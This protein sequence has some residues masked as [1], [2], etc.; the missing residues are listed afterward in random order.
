MKTLPRQ[1]LTQRQKVARAFGLS[2]RQL[3]RWIRF[4]ES[5]SLDWIRCNPDRATTPKH[6]HPFQ[7]W[8]LRQVLY[9]RAMGK[10]WLEPILLNGSQWTYQNWIATQQQNDKKHTA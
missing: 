3:T 5:N 8:L 6:L 1:R 10:E 4:I 7:E 2:D 9:H